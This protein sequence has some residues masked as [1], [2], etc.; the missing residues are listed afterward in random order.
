[1]QGNHASTEAGPDHPQTL[2]LFNDEKAGRRRCKLVRRSDEARMLRA[3]KRYRQ[4]RDEKRLGASS[5]VAKYPINISVAI[6]RKRLKPEY[7]HGFG[8]A[9]LK[10]WEVSWEGVD[11]ADGGQDEQRGIED[12]ERS[13]GAGRV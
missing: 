1:M 7:G 8:G 10:D 4:F 11:P 13:G 12:G 5:N 9:P 3:G 2:F 6:P